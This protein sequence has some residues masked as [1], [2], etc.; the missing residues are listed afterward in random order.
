MKKVSAFSL[1]EISIT[2][3]ILSVMLTITLSTMRVLQRHFHIQKQYAVLENAQAALI[4]YFL[5]NEKFPKPEAPLSYENGIIKGSWPQKALG[6]L[7]Y[8]IE[9]FVDERITEKTEAQP[10]L[11]DNRIALVESKITIPFV[12]K[13]NNQMIYTN[14]LALLTKYRPQA[15]DS[16]P[17]QPNAHGTQAFQPD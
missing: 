7:P 12:L 10:I 15:I 1:I 3:V 16:V 11:Y 2:L 14:F 13:L 5:L 9:Y 6:H 17:D 4:G 8:K